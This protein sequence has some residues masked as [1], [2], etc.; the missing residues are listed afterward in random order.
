MVRRIIP[1]LFV[2]PLVGGCVD[3]GAEPGALGG[4]CRLTLEPCNEGLVCRDTG[5]FPDDTD[6]DAPPEIDGVVEFPGGA[7]RLDADGEDKVQLRINAF[8]RETGE[9][10]AGEIRV[11]VDPEGAGFLLQGMPDEP[12]RPR[13]AQR[14]LLEGTEEGV[15]NVFVA[16]DAAQ[17]S[18]PGQAIIRVAAA[19]D[20]LNTIARS[21]TLRL[22]GGGLGGT[23]EGGEGGGG[24]PVN[25][26]GGS[27]SVSLRGEPNDPVHPKSQNYSDG[28]MTPVLR[29][30]GRYAALVYQ[31]V[32]DSP[33][34]VF[35]FEFLAPEGEEL[36]ARRYD[37]V[38]AVPGQD[39][40][41]EHGMRVSNEIEPC[42]GATGRF[43]IHTIEVVNGELRKFAASFTQ[44][45]DSRT[46][47]VLTGCV[48]YNSRR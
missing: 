42:R 5:C 32:P 6:P 18:C 48:S 40:G 2:I 31:T 4:E 36:T 35:T 45:C 33:T 1:W 19:H 15:V 46:D 20:P 9:P 27:T 29:G 13:T 10:W 47:A 7:P 30:E 34:D 43:T 23:G 24:G 28:V 41:A 44:Q 22:L 26:D 39:W 11:T 8:V 17:A 37:D 21:G 16:C 3:D 12:A 14:M 25:C 38:P